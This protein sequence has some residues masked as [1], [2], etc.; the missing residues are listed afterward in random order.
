MLRIIGGS[1]LL[2]A[3]SKRVDIFFTPYKSISVKGTLY[4]P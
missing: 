1:R 4:A 2:T 3:Y